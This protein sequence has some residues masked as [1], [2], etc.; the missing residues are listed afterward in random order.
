MSARCFSSSMNC[1]GYRATASVFQLHH[2]YSTTALFHLR[3]LKSCDERMLF[4]EVRDR[5]PQLARAVTV[6]DTQDLLIRDGGFV[7]KFFETGQRFVNR[8]PDHVDLG[9]RSRARLQIDID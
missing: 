7:E 3:R 5:T 9:Q 8:A 4:Q 1:W 2:S 6:N